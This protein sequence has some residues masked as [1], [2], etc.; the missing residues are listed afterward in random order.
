MLR[1]VSLSHG[2]KEAFLAMSNG[3]AG[4]F[5]QEGSGPPQELKDR[6]FELRLLALNAMFE[7]IRAGAGGSE[8][9]LYADEADPLVE[10]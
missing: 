7:G 6:A 9:I 2:E 10:P 4:E 3:E 8:F 5:R 1:K